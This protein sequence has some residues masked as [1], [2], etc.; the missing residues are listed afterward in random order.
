M[1][2]LC[3]PY[4]GELIGVYEPAL[5]IDEDGNHLTGSMLTLRSELMT[6]EAAWF[7]SG[8]ITT[9]EATLGPGEPP[10]RLPACAGR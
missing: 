8:A 10:S 6:P 5:V 2:R 4:C 9:S 3:C 7:M 1:D